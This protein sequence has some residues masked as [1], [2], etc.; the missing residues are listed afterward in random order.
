MR[1][2]A[3]KFANVAVAE[4]LAAEL[5]GSPINVSIIGLG[6]V[7]TRIAEGARNRPERYGAATETSPEAAEQLAALFGW[8][9]HQTK[10]LK[11]L[12]GVLWKT[13]CMFLPIQNS[14]TG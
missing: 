6:N 10:S 11:R 2:N 12:C 3:T 5:A 8:D 4:T 1:Y 13:N 7:Q 14:A 9:S